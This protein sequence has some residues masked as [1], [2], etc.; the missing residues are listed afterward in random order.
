MSDSPPSPTHNFLASA[1]VRMNKS[2]KGFNALLKIHLS[3]VSTLAALVEMN[4][5]VKAKSNQCQEAK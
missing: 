4:G 3:S 5:L 1:N 2:S